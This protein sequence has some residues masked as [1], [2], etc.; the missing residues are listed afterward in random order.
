MRDSQREEKKKTLAF[1]ISFQLSFNHWACTQVFI[2]AKHIWSGRWMATAGQPLWPAWGGSKWWET[3]PSGLSK[4]ISLDKLLPA[5][6]QH[7]D[8]FPTMLLAFQPSSS[9]VILDTSGFQDRSPVRPWLGERDESGGGR[10]TVGE[11]VGLCL[12]WKKQRVIRWF[13]GLL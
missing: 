11:T 2:V 9:G 1:S 8:R 10:E 3:S 6:S 4:G 5:Y 7:S 12:G 13:V